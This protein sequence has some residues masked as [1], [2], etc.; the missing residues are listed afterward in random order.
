LQVALNLVLIPHY[1]I[2]GA[3][4]SASASLIIMNLI[5]V[6]EG[7]QLVGVH[8]FERDVWKPLTAGVMSFGIVW[9][10]QFWLQPH[11]LLLGAGLM[12]LS[13]AALL[14]ALGFNDDDVV[15]LREAGDKLRR[16][17][18]VFG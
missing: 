4:V 6:V 17:V 9:S 16:V 1:G 11:R 12:A 8:P 3:A 15:V 2:I 5:R 14:I 7:W 10:L 18:A 13:Y